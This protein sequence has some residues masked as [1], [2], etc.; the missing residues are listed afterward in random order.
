MPRNFRGVRA[1]VKE[2]CARIYP[3]SVNWKKKIRQALNDLAGRSLKLALDSIF[4][5][6]VFLFLFFLTKINVHLHVQFAAKLS[7]SENDR[8]GGRKKKKGVQKGHSRVIRREL[9]RP[10]NGE[11]TGNELARSRYSRP[12]FVA[13]PVNNSIPCIISVFAAIS[14]PFALTSIM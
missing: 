2:S 5:T 11:W 1:S 13:A 12:F 6:F 7:R 10:L 3:R 8:G 14:R 4:S 9:F